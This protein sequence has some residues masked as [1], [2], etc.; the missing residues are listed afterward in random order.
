MSRVAELVVD[1]IAAGGD[2]VAR[3]E[4]LVVFVPRSAPGDRATVRIEGGG[5]FARGRLEA[6]L[7]P[8]PSRIDPPCAHYVADR[9]GGCQLQHLSYDAQLTAKAGIIRDSIQ[10]IGKRQVVLPDVRR[11]PR[12]WR[13]RRKLTL[14]MRR[15]PSSAWIAGLHPYDAPGRIFDLA[16]CPITDERVI[17][18]WRGVRTAARWLPDA[19]ELRGAVRI[20][21]DGAV[22]GTSFLLEGA[23]RWP[24]SERFF[25]AVP[26][27]GALWWRPEAQSRRRLH[28]RVPAHDSTHDTG[29][30]E[31]SV[32]D[33][34]DPDAG[35]ADASFV[36][37][38]ADVAAELHA[39]VVR[40]ALAHRPAT[41]VDAYAGGGDTAVPLATA[42]ARVTAIELDRD[43]AARASVRLQP[44][45]AV[46]QARVEDVL[47]AQLP[48]DVVILNPPRGGV[49]AAVTAALADPPARPRAI[50]YVSCNPA[51][52][53]RDIARL[54]GYR[55]ASL[56]AFDMFP[57][58]A[59]VETVCE[60][61]PEQS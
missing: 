32:Q 59:H 3:E 46:L 37:V 19:A 57:Q 21:S 17:A 30:G 39:Y 13:Y 33:S 52:L 35:T 54:P 23:R 44:P 1:S 26:S 2:G 40:L 43:G 11:S 9:C 8:G 49:D 45:S 24:D 53:A 50:V 58:T 47:R 29:A 51:T 6:I 34:S 56:L 42:G 27:I 22:E 12:E 7:D 36:Q 15:R 20:P 41:V 18:V 25:E 14:A 16:D 48:A 38:N 10:R 28:T 5:R 4:G 61:V 60:L 31:M 55:I